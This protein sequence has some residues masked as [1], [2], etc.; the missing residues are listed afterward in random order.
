MKLLTRLYDPT[1]GQIFADGVDLRAYDLA[2]WRKQTSAV[3]QD[4]ARYHVAA[5]ENIGFGQVER[6]ADTLAVRDAA[7]RGGADTVIARL[8]NGYDTVLG[9]VFWSGASDTKSVRVE[10]GVDLS[11]GEWQKHPRRARVPV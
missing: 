3:F 10:E 9:R 8:P 1:G 6:M 5:S 4:F 11:G 7:E 2:A